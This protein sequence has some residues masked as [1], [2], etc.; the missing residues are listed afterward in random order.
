MNA[1]F[2]HLYFHSNA[3][4]SRPGQDSSQ[5]PGPRASFAAEHL[6]A[7]RAPSC[8][9]SSYL[10]AYLLPT[11]HLPVYRT[12]ICLQSTY[13]PLRHLPALQ[14]QDRSVTLSTTW[15]TQAWH[16]SQG[17]KVESGGGMRFHLQHITTACECNNKAMQ[18]P[19]RP[20]PSMCDPTIIHKQK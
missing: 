19:A 15:C 8:L 9:S 16:V 3:E 14:A 10:L 13:L 6:P 1:I 5:I 18:P 17:S 12:P 11:G 20:E 4:G 7:C 2:H